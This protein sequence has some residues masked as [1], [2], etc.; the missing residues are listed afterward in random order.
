VGYIISG[1]A[2]S[3]GF[4]W[5]AFDPKRQGW[6]DKIARTYVVNEETTFDEASSVEIVPTDPGRNWLW[7][8]IWVVLAITMPGA[9]LASLWILG[10]VVNR[11]AKLLSSL[12]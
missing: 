1:L 6:H 3:L 8:I 7:L 10:P 2:L 4:I 9:L 5:L 12:L 11:F